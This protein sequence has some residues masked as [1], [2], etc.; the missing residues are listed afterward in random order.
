MFF[1]PDTDDV[2]PELLAQRANLL[3]RLPQPGLVARHP[4]VVPHD[5]P[6]LA[7]ELADRALA[8]D[9]EH[10]VDAPLRVAGGLA[11]GVM[12]GRHLR[13]LRAREVVRDRVGRDEVPVREPLHQRAGAEAVGAVVGEVR[14]AQHEQPRNRALEVV[15]H[16]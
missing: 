1:S 8:L 15:V 4:D 13:E 2:L 3:Q 12:V 11:E 7:V 9:A 6:K 5:V 16:P 14:F 10:R